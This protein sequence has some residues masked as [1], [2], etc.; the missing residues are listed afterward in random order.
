M[1]ALSWLVLERK[2]LEHTARQVNTAFKGLV[3]VDGNEDGK[4]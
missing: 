1:D 3:K 4:V 2:L